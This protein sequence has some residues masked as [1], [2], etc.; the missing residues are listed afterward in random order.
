VTL[1]YFTLSTSQLLADEDNYI[2]DCPYLMRQVSEEYR[3]ISKIMQ[4]K[5]P[6]CFKDI[7]GINFQDC[8]NKNSLELSLLLGNKATYSLLWKA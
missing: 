3:V 6:L 2:F 1:A 7:L 8:R 5:K 4:R